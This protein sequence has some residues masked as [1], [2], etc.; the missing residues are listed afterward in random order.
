MTSERIEKN[1]RAVTNLTEGNVL[2]VLLMFSLPIFIG[3]IFQQLYNVVDTVVIGNILGDDALAAV[4]S[5]S[6]VYSLLIGFVFGMSNGFSVVI[7]RFFG[8][9]DEEKMHRAVGISAILSVALAVI[10][11]AAGFFFLHPMMVFLRTPEEI[12][13]MAEEYLYIVMGLCCVTVLYNTLSGMLRA[14]GNSKIPL[15]AL[16]IASLV[17]VVLDILFVGPFGMGVKGAAIA[18]MIAQ[19]LSALV[20]LIYVIRYCPELHLK[21]EYIVRDTEITTELFSTGMSMSLM[22]VIVNVG[23]VAMQG[24]VNTFGVMTIT[25]HTAARKLHDILQLPLGTISTSIATFVSQNY[26]AGKMERVKEGIRSSIFLGATWCGMVLV[27][28]IILGRPVTRMLTG[29]RSTEVIDTTMRYLMWNIPFYIILNVLLIMRNSIQG[30]GRKVVPL[31]AS[32]VELIGK[33][34]AVF[35]MAP[36]LGYLGICLIE[37]LTWAVTAAIVGIAFY[38]AIKETGN[39]EDL[40]IAGEKA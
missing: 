27:F 12:L 29:T 18:T 6:A 24:A 23:T 14:L 34:L 38:Q 21:K 37:P 7:A 8:A 4:G 10:L 3:N 26:G 11:T 30:M 31:I 22:L 13:G 32:S 36:L 17:N 19:A 39:P 40:K 2:S 16:V 20:E 5:T 33:I 28:V 1:R 9:A 35:L 25:G 15:Y